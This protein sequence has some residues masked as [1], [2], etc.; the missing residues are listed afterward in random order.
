MELVNSRFWVKRTCGAVGADRW[1]IE[2]ERLA[3]Q[4]EL[5]KATERLR[6]LVA[7]VRDVI[8]GRSAAVPRVSDH[9]EGSARLSVRPWV[10]QQAEAEDLDTSSRAVE[11]TPPARPATAAS[12]QAAAVTSVMTDGHCDDELTLLEPEAENPRSITLPAWAEQCGVVGA[13]VSSTPPEPVSAADPPEGAS[14]LG[15]LAQSV[16]LPDGGDT[17]PSVVPGTTQKRDWA[18]EVSVRASETSVVGA[19]RAVQTA[20][21]RAVTSVPQQEQRDRSTPKQ[22]PASARDRLKGGRPSSLSVA[23]FVRPVVGLSTAAL[24]LV[25][26]GYWL[27]SRSVEA[28]SNSETTAAFPSPHAVDQPPSEKLAQASAGV[29]ATP[30][31]GIVEGAGTLGSSVALALDSTGPVPPEPATPP[32]LPVESGEQR[33]AAIAVRKSSPKSARPS[34]A[35]ERAKSRK[36][37]GTANS[38]KAPVETQPASPTAAVATA[39]PLVEPAAPAPLPT[40]EAP[41]ESTPP[42]APEPCGGLFGLKRAQCQSCDGAGTVSRYRC[43]RS[44]KISYCRGKWGDAPDCPWFWTSVEGPLDAVG[45]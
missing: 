34:Q 27:Y 8:A 6:D 12:A 24:L 10:Q 14:L 40:R 38:R 18:R 26:G 35:S 15:R 13:T 20:Q 43:E 1:P 2:A 21:W 3:A 39:A 29:A 5:V 19:L 7:A 36:R 17:V 23:K 30:P 44:V 37:G 16:S 32:A 41:V 45:P 11:T 33:D 4:N 9:A 31:T 25:V 42:A 28:T 22:P